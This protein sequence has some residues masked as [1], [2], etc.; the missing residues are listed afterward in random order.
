MRGVKLNHALQ[1][2]LPSV[3]DCE[4]VILF[5]LLP[6][7]AHLQ[8]QLATCDRRATTSGLSESTPQTL[9][10]DRSA[11]CFRSASLAIIFG[12]FEGTLFGVVAQVP[13]REDELRTEPLLKISRTKQRDSQRRKETSMKAA[14]V[15][16]R[17]ATL[18][19]G[20]KSQ[21]W[22]GNTR[23]VFRLSSLAP[24][25]LGNRFRQE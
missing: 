25:P 13:L 3:T 10:K 16:P 17:T 19:G 8:P 20:T 2:G 6:R 5:E 1:W 18:A 23:T 14:P 9:L 7:P 22:T 11:E 15:R 12:N 4:C 21:D 24:E